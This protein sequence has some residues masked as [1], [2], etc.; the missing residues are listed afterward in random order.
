M[1]DTNNS[2]VTT[3]SADDFLLE[4][5]TEELPPKAL[6]YLSTSLGENLKKQFDSADLSYGEVRLFA[7]PRRLAVLVNNLAAKQHDKIVEQ[8]GPKVTSA[9]NLDGSPTIAGQKFAEA[10]GMQVKELERVKDERGNT[11]VMAKK[12][13][14]GATAQ[15]LL[16]GIVDKALQG[17]PIPRQM[18]W[19]KGAVAF[20]RPVHWVVMLYGKEIVDGAILGVRAG[21]QTYGHRF[22]APQAI[23]IAA[24]Q[25]YEELLRKN[26][27][28]ADVVTRKTLISEDALIAASPYGTALID[29]ELLDEIANITEWPVALLGNFAGHF[30]QLPKELLILVLQKQQRCFPI[31]DAQNKL[32]AHFVAIANIESKDPVNVIKGNEKV[33]LARFT[34]ADFFYRS[35]VQYSLASY[36]DKLRATV[37]QTGLG[38]ICDKVQRLVEAASYIAE[39]IGGD[40][41]TAARAAELAKSDLMTTMVGEFPELQGIIGYYYA[42]H[43]KIPQNIALAMREQY[44]PGF[45]KDVLPQTLEGAALAIADRIDNIVGI[46]GLGKIPTGDRDPYGLRRAALGVLRIILE[47][48][49]DLDVRDL[50]QR[51]VRK[52]LEQVEKFDELLIKNYEASSNEH[53]NSLEDVAEK[54]VDKIVDFV[55]ERQR[56]WYLDAGIASVVFD[57]VRMRKPLVVRPVD[58]ERRLRAVQYFL[59]LEEAQA[60]SAAHKRVKNILASAI[61]KGDAG[62]E[63]DDGKVTWWRIGGVHHELNQK[64]LKEEAEQN[65]AMQ[66]TQTAQTV[67]DYC[68]KAQYRE[69]LQEMATLKL[70]VDNFFNTVM[71]MVDDEK[72]RHNRLALLRQL[73]DLFDSVADISYVG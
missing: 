23:T 71:V 15:N 55:F 28:M 22:H 25:D 47:K 63:N 65:L 31:F 11:Y 58:F 36:A 29:G 41:T 38:S 30:L 64:L 17:L 66:L 62:K 32:T 69:A 26:Y 10:S 2:T 7:T 40:V 60:L 57:A 46:F 43:E 9:F 35:D 12:M 34:D 6:S 49:L 37:F 16:P 67:R 24:P 61:S 56:S 59:T 53:E 5:G 8:R 21:N 73:Q 14:I 54:M 1:S 70:S 45:A 4:I 20:A 44:L 72:L 18:R 3:V 50:V 27:V 52:Y 42:L 68:A 19:G 33:V 48:N 13:R 39:V 51:S